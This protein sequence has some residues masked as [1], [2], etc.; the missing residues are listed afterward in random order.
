MGSTDNWRTQ[1]RPIPPGGRYPAKEYCSNCGLCDTYYVAHV[2]DAC[3]FL[4]E[5]MHKVETLEPQVHGRSRKDNL[6]R[7]F[8][9]CTA[10][11]S[12]KMNPPIQ[13]AQWT[14]VVTSIA[15]AL[16][17]NNWVDGVICVQSDPDDR[18][19]PRPVIATTVEAI[20]AARGVK[21]TL[22]PN[23]NILALLEESGLKRILF[24]G[25]GC[26]VQALRSIEHHLNL[27]Q[28]YVIGTHCVDNG[29]REGLEKF[30]QTTSDSP[31]T[32]QQYEFMQDY[33]V[34]LK[35][36]DGH[37]EK[38][39]YFCLPTRELNNVIAP[40]CYSC[41]DYM[42]GLADLVVGYMGVPYQNVPMTEHYQQI[43]IRNQKGVQM[44]ELIKPR[45]SIQGVE[46]EGDCRNF[47]LQT[48]FQEE[49]ASNSRLPKF[50]GKWLAAALTKFGPQ[51]LEFAKYSID[52]H[53]LRNYLFVKRNWGAKADSHIPGYAKEIVKEYD[54]NGKISR[55]LK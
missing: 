33:Q 47:V 23:L 6:E 24:C 49:R 50:I 7:R 40:S 13:G 26:Q 9:V 51:G 46:M 45:A 37:T 28:L 20:M 11:H 30:L 29:K 8:G 43:T 4:G 52:Y 1:S 41:F 42:N 39:P 3:A 48:V 16:L 32:V 54:Q 10:M 2:K 38:V 53:T 12:V 27:E 35:H 25:V 15:I 17:K 22:S 36:T 14:G 44:F 19:Q 34:H 5:G 18:L 21:P 55:L 31:E